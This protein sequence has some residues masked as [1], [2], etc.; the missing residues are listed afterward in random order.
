MSTPEESILDRLRRSCREIAG[1]ASF[2]RIDEERIPAYA[3]SLP[4]E[5]LRHLQMDPACHLLGRGEATAAFFLTLGAVNFGSG[6]FAELGIPPLQSGYRRIASALKDA[7]EEG[8]ALSAADLSAVDASSC[9][10]LF[11][12]DPDQ[13]AA[14][15]LAARYSRS[16]NQLGDWLLGRFGGTFSAPMAA[17]R[18][19]APHLVTLLAEIPSFR[20]ATRYRNLEI[21][22]LKRAQLAVT[23]LY[24]AFGGRGLGR[25]VDIDR[26]TICADNLVPHVLRL[27]GI[28]E[29]REDLSRRIEA[30]DPLPEGS[31]EE[32]EIRA[33]AVH[34][35]ELIVAELRRRDQAVNALRLDNLLWH[36][37]QQPR[38][39]LRPRHRTRTIFY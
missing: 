18:G 33:C 34:A 7:F 14:L 38:Y 15:E 27:D 1:T 29:Y 13:P 21:P 35:A 4:A 20:D 6:T 36:R 5:Q 9:L 19:S 12:L 8:G 28:L 26:L 2:V 11:G 31:A 39:R 23:D 10:E 17:A 37:G 16:L 32:V 24:I 30:G 25:F 22:F 3:G